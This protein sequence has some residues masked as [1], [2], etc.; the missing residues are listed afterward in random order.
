MLMGAN[1]S[2]SCVDAG[3]LPA[4]VEPGGKFTLPISV[5][6]APDKIVDETFVLFTDHP[7]HARLG[8]RLSTHDLN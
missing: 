7:N 6:I 1:V 4:Q 8:V 3:D 2:C 5:K